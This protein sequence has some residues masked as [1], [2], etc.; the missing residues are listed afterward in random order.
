M[1]KLAIMLLLTVV[2]TGFVFAA[3]ETETTEEETGLSWIIEE[4]DNPILPGVNPLEVDGDIVVAGSST[5]FPLAEEVIARWY[6]EGYPADQSTTYTSIGSGGGFERFGNGETDISGAS[7][8]IEDDEV[9]NARASG[10]EPEEFIVAFD[11][12][13]VVVNPAN[14]WAT[15][16]TIDELA[17]VF[18]TAETW[19]DVRDGFPEVEI[20]RY[21]PGT[22]SGTFD[23]FVEAVFE[24]DEG[25]ILNAAR[26]QFSEDD[27]VLV[28]GVEGDEGAIGFFGFAYLVEAGDELT[29]VNV[30]GIEPSGDTVADGTYPLARPLFIYSDAEIMRSKPQVA[31]FINFFLTY[32]EEEALE[33]GY[34]PAPEARINAARE[35]WV[36]IMDGLY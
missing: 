11:A 13:A 12:L 25:P 17:A 28:Q 7:R 21:V 30:E 29:A 3:G 2:A 14:D 36:E 31:A 35:R 5:V 32:G 1:R 4:G 8:P 15:E 33:V 26:A 34:F 27:N 9:E 10:L 22:D 23:Y 18:S 24:E 6:D 20:T 19:A 16:L